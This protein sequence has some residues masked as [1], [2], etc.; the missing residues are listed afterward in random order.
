MGR[1]R[2]VQT[3]VKLRVKWAI[4]TSLLVNHRNKTI[5]KAVFL[6]TILAL[7]SLMTQDGGFLSSRKP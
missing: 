1:I 5:R 2:S 4:L 6:R 3:L 7:I